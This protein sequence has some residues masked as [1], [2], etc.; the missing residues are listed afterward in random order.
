MET[1][2][3]DA[4][5]FAMDRMSNSMLKHFRRSPRHYLWEK[6]NKS[7][8]TPAMIIGSAFHCFVLENSEFNDRFAVMPKVDRRTTAGKETFAFFMAENQGKTIIEQPDFDMIRRMNDAL[9]RDDFAREL[10]E[11]G[12]ETEKPFLWEEQVTKV[13]MKGKMDR[14]NGSFTLDLK[15]C[16]SAHPETAAR[17]AFDNYLTQPAVYREAR[18]MNGMNKGDFYFLFV[19]KEQPHGV[20][21]MKCGKDF[22][23]QG[24]LTYVSAMEDF[25]FWQEMGSPDVGYEWRKPLGY[26]M[27]N[28]PKWFRPDNE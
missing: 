9:F 20:S 27:L 1:P 16:V 13:P 8:P 2:K 19:E 26:S 7:E 11:A 28:L 12:G 6:A 17:S 18:K 5:Y 4:E 23:E 21:V 24:A 3:N 25:R 15:S 10:L 22:L 14:V